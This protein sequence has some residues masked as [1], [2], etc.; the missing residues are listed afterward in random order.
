MARNTHLYKLFGVSVI[1]LS[2]F[3]FIALAHPAIFPSP[4]LFFCFSIHG[5]LYLGSLMVL[6]PTSLMRS[7]SLNSTFDFS[8]VLH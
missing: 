8:L 4:I 1:G 7:G 6:F 2:N 5:L 3:F